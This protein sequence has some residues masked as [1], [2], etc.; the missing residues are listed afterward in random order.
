[1]LFPTDSVATMKTDF[2]FSLYH[3]T[4]TCVWTACVSLSDAF[5]I[6]RRPKALLAVLGANTTS[7]NEGDER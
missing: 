3:L 4:A 6:F 2:V 7:E 5:C 1:M